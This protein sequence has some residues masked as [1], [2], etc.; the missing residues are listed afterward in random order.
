VRS[1]TVTTCASLLAATLAAG[2]TGL[3]C[4]GGLAAPPGAARVVPV[5]TATAVTT[6]SAHVQ[7]ES[8]LVR[9]VVLSV[10]IQRA[11]FAAGEPVTY[12]VS[13]KNL[14]GTTCTAPGAVAP[15]R[16]LPLLLGECSALPV[17]VEDAQ[18][19]VVYPSRE[20]L[21]C[22]AIVGPKLG[23]HS[24]LHATGT[25]DPWGIAS[26]GSG[27]QPGTYRL[28]VDARVVVPFILA[29]PTAAHDTSSASTSTRA[30]PSTAAS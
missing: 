8:C 24:A 27:I 23:P 5:T 9:D 3:V 29:G 28:I 1:R 13:L 30:R 2:A 16:P 11:A 19:R 14:A 7:Y 26:I 22:P 15:K 12:R 20:A 18:G 4:L 21:S 25:W 17:A 10:S 6:K